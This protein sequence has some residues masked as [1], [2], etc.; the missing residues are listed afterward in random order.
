VVGEGKHLRFRVRQET[1]QDA[2]SAIAFRLGAQLDRYRRIGRYD[3]TFRLEE[4]HWNGTVAPQLVVQRIFETPERYA[5]VVARFDRS[6]RAPPP[7]V[8]AVLEE[9]GVG[10]GA[11]KRHLLESEA[12]RNLLEEPPLAA[13]A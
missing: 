5:D 4:N 6:W 7:E 12:F 10:D 11:P 9:L 13:A 1:G 2:G 8:V 3:V